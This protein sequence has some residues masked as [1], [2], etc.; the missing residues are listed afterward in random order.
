MS[1]KRITIVEV[2]RA[3]GVDNSTVSLALRGDRRIAEQT[4]RR[5]ADVAQR[6]HYV[7]N[8]LAS[9][10]SS[11]RSRV[12]GVMLPGLENQ[13][14]APHLEEFQAA[15]ELS[16]NAISI[17]CCDWD[18]K[19]EEHGLSQFCESR[20]DGLI[21]CPAGGAPEHIKAIVARLHAAEI[22]FVILGGPS[23]LGHLVTTSEDQALKLGARYL[24]ALGH[25]RIGIATATQVPGL[26]GA[27]HRN[28]LLRMREALQSAGVHV[29]NAD[30]FDTA[31]NEYG[32]VEF[33]LSLRKR[34]PA[35]RPTAIYAAD[36]MLARAV[37]MGLRVVGIGVP[38]PVS[39]LGFDDA[40]RDA[41]GPV[42]IT[43]VSLE[44]RDNGRKAIALLLDLIAKRLP[45]T[46]F[47]TIRVSPRIVERASCLGVSP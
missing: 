25:R 19:R 34:K 6:L 22:K 41:S 15:A 43:T 11:G 36:D 45:P 44:A 20:V 18:L 3:A 24:V 5:V 32:G 31:D 42:P 40:P 2:A 21:W 29:E 14:F 47:K 30:I 33:A 17:K 38:S 27:L 4:R 9:A 26:R 46:P 16:R 7:P 37:V 10:L 28:R 23:K 35:S 12:I 1:T 8:Q 39:V 13:F